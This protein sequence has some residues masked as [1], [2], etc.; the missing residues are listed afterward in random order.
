MSKNTK[1]EKVLTPSEQLAKLAELPRFSVEVNLFVELTG[2]DAKDADAAAELL[3]AVQALR[4]ELGR[5]VANAGENR[6]HELCAADGVFQDGRVR[7]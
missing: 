5:I 4:S 7:G 6:V 1:S 3:P 2:W